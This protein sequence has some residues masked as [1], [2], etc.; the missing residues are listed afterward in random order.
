M[1]SLYKVRI[2]LLVVL[3]LLLTILL[4][5]KRELFFN[6]SKRDIKASSLKNHIALDKLPRHVAIMM[7]G[8]GRWAAKQGK[9]R[10][11]GHMN[12]LQSVEQAI[13]VCVELGIPY[14]TLFAFSTENWERPREEVNRLMQLFVTTTRDK[15]QE[16]MENKVKLQVIGDINRL[17][18]ECQV[19]LRDAIQAT[20]NNK[21]LCLIVALSY[22]G[23]WDIT[24]AV[25][26]LA[27]EVLTKKIKPNDISAE[28]FQHYLST[29]EVPDP[30]LLIRTGGD[31][32][33]SNFLLWQLAYTELAFVDKYWPEFRKEDFYKALINYQQRDR[34]FGKITH[35]P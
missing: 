11:F 13:A 33:I 18:Q 35:K 31:I 20:Q 10:V 17:P 28:I 30:D 8:N 29:S 1:K 24:Q 21:G 16:L 4:Y 15:L 19:V 12:S 9:P 32:R 2:K 7:D 26:A 3:G 23:K 25:R 14:L 22:S 6:T 27:H 5:N 34:R